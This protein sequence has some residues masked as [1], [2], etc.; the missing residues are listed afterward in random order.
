MRKVKVDLTLSGRQLEREIQRTALKGQRFR[1]FRNLISVILVCSAIVVLVSVFWFPVFQVTGNSMEPNLKRGQFVVA[2]RGGTVAYG[3]MVALH[4][5]NQILIRR[6]IGMPGDW[7]YIDD[8]GNISINNNILEETYLS[9]KV[10]GRSDLSYPYQV[11]D[12]TY[13]VMGDKRSVALDS[14]RSSMGCIRMDKI[15]GKI[16][17]CIWPINEIKCFGWR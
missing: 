2:S 4:F 8:Q 15:A 6:V 13:F 14:R 9:E 12:G 17:F 7:I 10:R 11:P 3:D 16:T 1:Y 5:E